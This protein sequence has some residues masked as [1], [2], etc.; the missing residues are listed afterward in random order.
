VTV[1]AADPYQAAQDL[2]PINGPGDAASSLPAPNKAQCSKIKGRPRD[3]VISRLAPPLWASATE[4]SPA[5]P[6][7]TSAPS[8]A[9]CSLQL[10]MDPVTP[11]LQPALTVNGQQD[12]SIDIVLG[13]DVGEFG[14]FDFNLV[15]DDTRLAPIGGG[16]GLNGNPDFNDAALGTG[17]NCGAGLSG[18]PD[19]D[20]E[21]G[22]GHGVA[23]ISC[24][25]TGQAP[26]LGVPTAVATLH[27]RFLAAGDAAIDIADAHFAHYD[28]TDI[29]S[30]NPVIYQAMT[31]A[32]GSVTGN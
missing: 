5:A 14:A 30:C 22:P 28:A 25:V 27:L 9:C 26:T 16:S 7:A 1:Y 11:G 17:W 31:C 13:D 20:P 4:E 12:I 18:Q 21:T 8:P 3:E 32:G 10:D 2:R 29:G 6:L 19:I 15:Y 23:F 24:Y